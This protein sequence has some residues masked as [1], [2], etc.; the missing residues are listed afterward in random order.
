MIY[1][2]LSIVS[3]VLGFFS[4]IFG[5]AAVGIV[6]LLIGV[7][8]L[9]KH[10][11]G[12]KKEEKTSETKTGT[13]NAECVSIQKY[14]KEVVEQIQKRFIAFD[15]E[16]TGLNRELDRVVQVGAVLFEEGKPTKRFCTLVNPEMQIPAQ[17]SEI[18][19]I[20]DDMVA[21]APLEKEALKEL[22]GFFGDAAKK[23][24]VICAHNAPF[25]MAFLKNMIC[26]NGMSAQFRYA[27]TLSLAR[28][29]IPDL[30]NY[31][32]ATIAEN[33]QLKTEGAHSAD[34][35]AELCGMIL[36]QL[37]PQ[38]LSEEKSNS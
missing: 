34:V 19:H 7:V 11:K 38:L 21:E 14:S 15:V 9:L 25:D 35:D 16:T 17:V 12:K 27:D 2:N 33:F 28:K 22:L 20:T 4:L 13:G 26:R 29:H 5:S 31:K 18:N 36:V 3:F 1:R 23:K 30:K 24:T 37:L 6:L 10:I 8:L 32:L